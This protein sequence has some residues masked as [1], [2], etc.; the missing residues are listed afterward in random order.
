M[1]SIYENPFSFSHL[2][3]KDMDSSIISHQEILSHCFDFVLNPKPTR[4]T[5]SLPPR[6][7]QNPTNDQFLTGKK[8]TVPKLPKRQSLFWG[9]QWCDSASQQNITILVRPFSQNPRV[10]RHNIFGIECICIRCLHFEAIAWNDHQLI[11]PRASTSPSRSDKGQPIKSSSTAFA[12]REK[13]SERVSCA[14]ARD[15][16]APWFWGFEC[17]LT[18]SL[19]EIVNPV[20]PNDVV[21]N[22]CIKTWIYFLSLFHVKSHT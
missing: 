2:H 7:S 5:L 10:Q 21:A 1:I 22:D 18:K 14:D 9:K 12:L 16:S 13:I 19:E 3:E 20:F 8:F 17:F 11:Y 6:C 4:I 15:E